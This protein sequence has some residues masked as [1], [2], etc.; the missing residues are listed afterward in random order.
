MAMR[1]R[2]GGL[3]ATL[4]SV[5][6][7]AAGT[8]QAFAVQPT[9]Q[10][11]HKLMD[12]I[13]LGRSL[14][15]MNTQIAASMKQSLPCVASNYWQDFVDENGSKEFIGRLVP[16][17]QKHFSAEEVDGMVAFYSSSLGQKVLT[18]MPAA[19]AEATQAGQQWSH[20]HGQ[21]MIAK[22]EQA[23]TLN[24]EG[25]CP[26]TGGAAEASSSAM[27][28]AAAVDGSDSEDEATPA[29]SHGKAS[30]RSH[31]HG[32]VKKVAPKKPVKST[33]RAKTKPSGSKTP[34]AKASS[35]KTPAKAK[36]KHQA[37]A[38]KPAS[39]PASGT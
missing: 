25:R 12:A 31:R 33:T 27:P 35:T 3:S 18:E 11:V 6:L 26:A 10:Q 13:G 37:A 23:G 7:L 29:V 22:L 4:L 16:I 24:Q 8:G 1:K 19:M 9:E 5:A 34:P 28:V 39:A 17:Y 21:Q 15:Q 30:S 32:T 38:A 36:P 14:N 2:L 20:E